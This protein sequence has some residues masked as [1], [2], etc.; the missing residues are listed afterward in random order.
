MVL[1][2][3]GVLAMVSVTVFVWSNAGT[4]KSKSATSTTSTSTSQ[5]GPDG[6]ILR[7][8]HQPPPQEPGRR[9]RRRRYKKR[10]HDEKRQ[11]DQL[12]KRQQRQ[13]QQGAADD[14]QS[15]SSD[16][17]DDETGATTSEQQQQQ[18]DDDNDGDGN[19]AISISTILPAHAVVSLGLPYLI[20]GTAWKQDDTAR[21]VQM[22]ITAGFRFIDTA[23]QPKHYHENGVGDGWTRAADE[24]SLD[25]RDLF[26]QT[27]FTS[28]SG[29]D[30]NNIPYDA[31]QPLAEQVAESLQV[32][33]RNLRT[34]Y[35]D[36]WVMHGLETNM[37]DTMIVYRAMELAVD[38]GKVLRLGIANCYDMKTFRYI[39]D[40]AR[41]KPE[42]LQN[43]FYQQSHWDVELRQFCQTHDIW[44]QSFWTLTANDV[45][46]KSR[47]VVEWA[48]SKNLTP[49]TLLYAY[50]MNLGYG[51]PLDGTKNLNHMQQDIAVMQR[52]QKEF[53][54]P[55]VEN[56]IFANE[57]EMRNFERLLGF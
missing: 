10:R 33:L 23:C 26:L 40:N 31:T 20:Y 21:L 46:L 30:P 13:Q 3:V 25:R 17:G 35:L 42:I 14:Q 44:Y 34:T 2:G 36:S 38:Q 32:S 49:Q 45:A 53:Q 24:L 51:T 27:K 22:A 41:I 43:R 5:I 12:Q 7:V 9:R 6:Q 16:E 1:L 47:P 15:E 50:L 4:T 39:Y 48:I 18:D 57:H 19:R 8:Q 55:D 28:V 54:D 56:K 52:M 11:M 37:E 29:Q